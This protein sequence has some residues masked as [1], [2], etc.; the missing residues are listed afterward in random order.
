[1]LRRPRPEHFLRRGVFGL[2]VA[3]WLIVATTAG[4]QIQ[5]G[6]TAPNFTKNRLGGGSVSLSDYSGQVVVLFLLGH[7]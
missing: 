3:M 1:M 6:E 5:V 7:G 4:A 2:A